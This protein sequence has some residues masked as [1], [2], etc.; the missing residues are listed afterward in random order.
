MK[1]EAPGFLIHQ[2]VKLNPTLQRYL[3][4]NARNLARKQNKHY[5]VKSFAVHVTCFPL[6]PFWLSSYYNL[7]K[8]CVLWCIVVKHWDRQAS[9]V[10]SF[11]YLPGAPL[12]PFF[13]SLPGAPLCSRFGCLPGVPLCSFL[14]ASMVP[15]CTH[16]LALSL[17]P[18]CVHVLAPSLVLPCAHFLAASLVLHILLFTSLAHLK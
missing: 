18:P 6:W 12:C 4:V 3:T 17:V 16:F 10:L 14:A 15:P 8:G 13:G 11:G 2:I 9:L 7:P 1:K 5:V